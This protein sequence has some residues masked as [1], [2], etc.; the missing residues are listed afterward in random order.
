MKLMFL[1]FAI[2]VLIFGD[3]GTLSGRSDNRDDKRFNINVVKLNQIAKS[4]K[5][6]NFRRIYIIKC[7]GGKS[8]IPKTLISHSKIV[9]NRTTPANKPPEI[10]ATTL[11]PSRKQSVAEHFT[12]PLK[13]NVITTESVETKD[14]TEFIPEHVTEHLK[15]NVETTES[16]GTKDKTESIPAVAEKFTEP[17]KVSVE[18]TESQGK[19]DNTV[20]TVSTPETEKALTTTS[21]TT[22]AST[23]YLTNRPT[24][25]KTSTIRTTTIFVPLTAERLF[26]CSSIPCDKNSFYKHLE[27]SDPAIEYRATWFSA[28]GNSFIFGTQLLTWEENIKKCCSIGMIPISIEN[29]E[30][31]SCMAS[32]MNP[33]WPFSTYYW[34]S[35]RKLFHL[36]SSFEFCHSGAQIVTRTTAKIWA[37]LEPSR[38]WD[39]LCILM[40]FEKDIAQAQLYAKN[41][42]EKHIFSCQGPLTTTQPPNLRYSNC[43]K[44]SKCAKNDALFTSLPNGGVLLKDYMSYGTWLTLSGRVYLISPSTAT[45]KDAAAACCSIGLNLLSIDYT[46]KYDSLATLLKQ[47]KIK[48]NI[49][50]TSGARIGDNNIFGWCATKK[51]VRDAKW[52]P[53][54][55]GSADDCV[56]V[57]LM[58]NRVQIEDKSCEIN[59][60]Y[61]CEGRDVSTSST[62]GR[63]ILNECGL[64]YNITQDQADSLWTT[65]AYDIRLKCYMQCV[66]EFGNMMINGQILTQSMMNMAQDMFWEKNSDTSSKNTATAIKCAN[67][68]GMDE[69][70]TASVTFSCIQDESPDMIKLALLEVERS[71]SLEYA[72]LPSAQALCSTALSTDKVVE[73]FRNQYLNE[74]RNICM[75]FPDNLIG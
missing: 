5:A 4:Q 25:I 55:P 31:R 59:Y 34:T 44:I 16:Q 2:S 37:Y 18:T 33:D 36:N 22:K 14:E 12:E 42:S 68:A 73:L 32:L 17:L 26:S 41:C 69:C 51:R 62:A 30:K 70:D 67:Q 71:N 56:A 54:L 1:A 58:N 61:I 52:T 64:L 19:K 66:G 75:T 50:W 47:N 7:C 10:G 43:Q 53:G 9:D 38:L 48:S 21:Y 6:K 39:K 27:A 8:C 45:W 23:I 49:Y 11:I 28:C 13:M 24:V 65:K 74:N 20:T 63:A 29:E 60:N 57:S 46:F 40:A 15:V 35:G 72:A 3:C